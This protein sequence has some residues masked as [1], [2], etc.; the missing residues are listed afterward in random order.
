[1][2]KTFFWEICFVSV[3]GKQQVHRSHI[4][5]N[6]YFIV[7][8]QGTCVMN[9]NSRNSRLNLSKSFLFDHAF[10]SSNLF[11]SSRIAS[12]WL[13]SHTHNRD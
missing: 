11:F 4:T 13:I 8:F 7:L 1:M 6:K 10:L 12:Y 3:S 9:D 2:T 5:N